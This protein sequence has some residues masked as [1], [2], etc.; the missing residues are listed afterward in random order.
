M[1]FLRYR[2][3]VGLWRIFKWN[4]KGK[5]ELVLWNRRVVMYTCNRYIY[6]FL[7]LLTYLSSF[8]WKVCRSGNGVKVYPWTGKNEYMILSE[9]DFI[10][11]GG[12]FVLYYSL[13]C[14]WL[15]TENIDHPVFVWNK[16]V[17]ANLDYG[18]T[19]TSSVATASHARHLTTKHYHRIQN[20]HASNS[21]FGVSAF[22][23]CIETICIFFF[24]FSCTHYYPFPMKICQFSEY[25]VSWNYTWK[26]I[27]T[28]TP[29][30][31]SQVLTRIVIK[32]RLVKHT[33]RSIRSWLENPSLQ[34]DRN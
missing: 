10:A 24:F 6:T 3:H 23:S 27:Y 26:E 5:P 16:P 4:S 33:D 22:S 11:I 32:T 34:L 2:R 29:N 21:K 13:W 8:L 31:I 19:L 9:A 17:M 15:L 20:S 1:H 30:D 7:L 28:Q 25:I 12:G 14:F 18:S